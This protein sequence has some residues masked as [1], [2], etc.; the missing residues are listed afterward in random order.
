MSKDFPSLP[1]SEQTEAVE[2]ASL[3]ELKVGDFI[4]IKRHSGK[5]DSGWRIELI[6]DGR[7][8]VTKGTGK[9]AILR[10]VSQR[11][12]EDWNAQGQ[13]PKPEETSIEEE[14][15]KSEGSQ[16][17]LISSNPEGLTDMEK[18]EL[19]NDPELSSFEELYEALEK[20]GPVR[21]SQEV[22]QPAELINRINQVIGKKLSPMY[23]TGVYDIRKVVMRLINGE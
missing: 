14:P 15:K 7:V 8:I 2:T 1:D 3:L 20:I 12:L 16:K 10:N 4:T 19:I 13:N 17:Q 18:W 23:I 22:F 9:D 11:D 21:G 6:A 5:M